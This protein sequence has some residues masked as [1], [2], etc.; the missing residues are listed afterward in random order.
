[1]D[2]LIYTH[3]IVLEDD[4]KS[5]MQMHRRLNPAIKDVVKAKVLK[6]PNADIIYP[7]ANN[8]WVSLI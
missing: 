6:L 2:F 7:I 1:M 3:Y 8:K 4:A 5:T